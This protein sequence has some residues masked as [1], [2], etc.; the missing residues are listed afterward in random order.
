VGCERW[1]AYT[2]EREKTYKE[3][4]TNQRITIIL[5]DGQRKTARR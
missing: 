5:A 3:R 2:A 4:M 1:A